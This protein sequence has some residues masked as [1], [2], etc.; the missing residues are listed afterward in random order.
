MVFNR[1]LSG[2]ISQ[3]GI[4]LDLSK[5][6]L[7]N[8]FEDK[9]NFSTV[10]RLE[11]V[12]DKVSVFIDRTKISDHKKYIEDRKFLLESLFE[13]T[14]SPYPEVIT[15]IIE[16]PGEFKP[17]INE[18][19]NGVIYTLFAGER[20]NYGVCAHDLVKYQSLYGIFDCKGKGVFEVRIFSSDSKE[21]IKQT[22]GSFKC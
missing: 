8:F 19:K 12:N 5:F 13:P 4:S 15:N 3:W 7:I 2:H 22:M 18:A 21:K 16:C 17:K 9:T 1:S 10:Q 6:E 14:T 20:Y 11:A